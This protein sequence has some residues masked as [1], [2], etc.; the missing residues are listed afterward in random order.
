[1]TFLV[2]RYLRYL[3]IG[4]LLGIFSRA[5]SIT[6]AWVLWLTGPPVLLLS[7]MILNRDLI[8]RHGSGLRDVFESLMAFGVAAGVSAFHFIAQW[9]KTY[10]IIVKDGGAVLLEKFLSFSQNGFPSMSEL[11]FLQINNYTG[12]PFFLQPFVE[13]L[14]YTPLS[15][16]AVLIASAALSTGVFFLAYRKLFN[17]K[18][19]VVGVLLLLTMRQYT[20]FRWFDYTYTVLLCSVLFYLYAVYRKNPR[21]HVILYFTAYLTGVFIYFKATIAL[22]AAGLASGFL[23][24]NKSLYALKKIVPCAILVLAGA[25]PFIGYNALYFDDIGANERSST[26]V[27]VAGPENLSFTNALL[28]RFDQ[29][30]RWM[31][32]D[33]YRTKNLVLRGSEFF[34]E[35]FISDRPPGG[36]IQRSLS[37]ESFLTGKNYKFHSYTGFHLL[38]A[39]LVLG[40]FGLII[41]KNKNRD[42][43]VIWSSF[44]VLMVFLPS[45]SGFRIAHMHALV[46]FTIP[47]FLALGNIIPENPGLNRKISNAIYLCL[48][49]VLGLA[50][51]LMYLNVPDIDEPGQSEF[52]SQD[53]WGG[54][55][56]FYQDF[57]NMEATEDIVTNSVKVKRT[58]AYSSGRETRLMTTCKIQQDLEFVNTS[59]HITL[60]INHGV[61]NNQQSCKTEI[62]RR[63]DS[64]EI[65]A[66]E[67][68]EL[69]STN[70]TVHRP[71]SAVG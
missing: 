47:V 67:T 10:R 45:T 58:S 62:S 21:N 41:F 40:S 29:L 55:S 4:L 38:S 36:E 28:G 33:A 61:K 54:S 60:I 23:S 70:V 27:S 51:V 5:L 3:L 2:E 19:A 66:S 48:C 22:L 31:V 65:Y 52:W 6:V 59:E 39:T 20:Y 46:P 12:H 56:E 63:L 57:E 42:L 9:N 13:I 14:G 17:F 32:S 24:A 7:Y 30:G 64:A 26:E 8:F 35:R 49:T 44:L 18:K 71:K 43:A 15:V 34:P 37:I 16:R 11:R 50:A 25:L 68:R 69:G 1:M 53:D